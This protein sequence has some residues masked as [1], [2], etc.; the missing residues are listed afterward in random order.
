MMVETTK[1][2]HAPLNIYWHIQQLS[3]EVG[4]DAIETKAAYKSVRECRIGAIAA[5]ALF[6]R[7][8]KPA[9]VQL[10]KRDPP[11][12]FIIQPSDKIGGQVDITQI[13]ITSYLKTSE[14]S[15]LE[16]LRRTKVPAGINLYSEYYVL[17][18][19]LGVGL[20]IDYAPIR[21]YLNENQ[22]PFPVWTLQ[23]IQRSPNTTA[24][25][26]II[27]P[28]TK[29]IDLDVGKTAYLFKKL[30]LPDVV[31]IRRVGKIGSMHTEPA[32]KCHDAPW[33][34]IGK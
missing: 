27:N 22:T 9:Y 11:D 31:V 12:V 7:T 6:Q 17:L 24:R 19:N 33:E 15:L 18:V 3:K 14:E 34:T 2:W 23:E 29:E 13:E 21:K 32:G 20:G 4:S 1:F 10:C 25:L 28:E 30:K 26:V 16:Q 5:L 8:G